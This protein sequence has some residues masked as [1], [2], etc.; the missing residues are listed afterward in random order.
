[1]R[2]SIAASTIADPGATSSPAR[3]EEYEA[4]NGTTIAPN[5]V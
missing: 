3:S 4:A 1:M 5:R 2:I